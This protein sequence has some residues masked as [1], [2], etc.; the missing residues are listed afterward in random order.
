MYKRQFSRGVAL[1]LDGRLEDVIHRYDRGNNSVARIPTQAC[2]INN[3]IVEPRP[4]DVSSD[5]RY[6]LY[7]DGRCLQTY[8]FTNQLNTE[9][10]ATHGIFQHEFKSGQISDTG[11][12]VTASSRLLDNFLIYN[13]ETGSLVLG[14]DISFGASVR[15]TQNKYMSNDGR[16]VLFHAF[17]YRDYAL[18]DTVT[19]ELGLLKDDDGS[20]L[21]LIH[22]LSG[23]GKILLYHDASTLTSKGR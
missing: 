23:N 19:G 3:G 8:D 20:P 18:Y 7:S 17:P 4:L 21:F 6:L 11:R 14:G 16:F 15:D 10:L 13:L 9:I 22:N 2:E 12:I 1:G 5:G